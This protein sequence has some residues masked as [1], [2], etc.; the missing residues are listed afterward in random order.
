MRNFVIPFLFFLASCS[1][2]E[3]QEIRKQ[4]RIWAPIER[5]ADEVR[6]TF[7]EPEPV[8]LPKYPWEKEDAEKDQ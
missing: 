7:P 3:E 6:Y 8:D 4:N 2:T 5:Q 1:S